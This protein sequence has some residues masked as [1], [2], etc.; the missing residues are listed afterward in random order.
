VTTLESVSEELV[1]AVEQCLAGWVERCVAD[2]S[3]AFHGAM[4]AATME[5]SVAAGRA[6]VDEV[7]PKLRELLAT[8]I[9]EQ[10]TNPLAIVRGAVTH[11]T[12]VLLRAGVS[13]VVR[14]DF[15]EANF[16][17]DIYALSPAAFSDIDDRLHEPGLRWGAAKAHTHLQR[18]R[19]DGMR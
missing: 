17:D 5:Q 4:N 3:I 1:A 12:A 16:P 7:V 15:A 6:A 8:D 13:P 9:D 14:D 11:P 18:R 2:L 10:R 19:Q